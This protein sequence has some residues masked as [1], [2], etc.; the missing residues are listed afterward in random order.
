[1]KNRSL[2]KELIH[3]KIDDKHLFFNPYSGGYIVTD[4]VGSWFINDYN[5][6]TE[7][8]L[9]K[10][11]QFFGTDEKKTKKRLENYLEELDIVR[12]FQ[13]PEKDNNHIR[14]PQS[15]CI[16]ITSG[17]NLRC[18]T[19]YVNS[20]TPDSSEMNTKEIKNVVDQL[21]DLGVKNISIIGGEPLIRKDLYEIVKYITERNIAA[22]ISTNGTLLNDE[23][24]KKISLLH[25]IWVQVSLDGSTPDIHDLNRGKGAFKK[26]MNGINLL[27]KYNIPFSISSVIMKSNAKDVGRIC[28]LAN[29]LG[30]KS[31]I[32]HKLHS[33]GRAIKHKELIPKTEE[34]IYAM[35]TIL[36]KG[37][38]YKGKL[39]VDLPH[40]RVFSGYNRVNVKYIGCHFGRFS[41]YINSKGDITTCSHLQNGAYCFGNIRK[42]NIRDVWYNSK[43]LDKLRN[44]TV[45]DIESC[46]NCNY[47]YACRG[48]CRA[49]AYY[50]N[51]S[52]KSSCPDCDALRKYY[53]TV[54][55]FLL[56][57]SK[58]TPL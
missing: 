35:T 26:A 3:E 57:H 24:V 50:T 1:M 56:N 5:G 48:S 28:D 49:E 17:C 21:T 39:V 9:D 20:S 43:A 55:Q 52:I 6:D 36:N 27:K 34:L 40:N 41:A 22:G 18:K 29:S 11:S 12:M 51:G 44:L 45:T 25:N 16:E 19:C 46:S 14:P 53:N 54:F 23:F 8:L 58:I 37:I 10:Y 42:D 15:S 4:K 38:E 32:F 13:L 47:K 7:P 30:A 33:C 2:P 31:I